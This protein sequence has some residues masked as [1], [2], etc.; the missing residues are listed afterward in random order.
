MPETPKDYK[1]IMDG[2][3]FKKYDPM[4]VYAYVKGMAALY[5][6]TWAR[7]HP[8]HVVLTVSPG[9]SRGT[10][11]VAQDSLSSFMKFMFPIVLKIFS[12]FG[13]AHTASVGAKRYVDAMNHDGE[14]EKM[15][16]GAFWASLHGT[17]GR[18]GDQKKFRKGAQYGDVSKQEAAY[19]AIQAYA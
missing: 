16:S 8:E 18:V 2:S 6:S 19:Q 14:F 4:S 12:I 1:S 5:W 9:A 10:N 7:K 11:A 13:G 3:A 15:E 17:S